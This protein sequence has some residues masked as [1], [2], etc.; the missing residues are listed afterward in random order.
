LLVALTTTTTTTTTTMMMTMTW[1]SGA[2]K[3]KGREAT[4]GSWLRR[5]RRR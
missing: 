4:T 3:W 2:S 5:R 1:T